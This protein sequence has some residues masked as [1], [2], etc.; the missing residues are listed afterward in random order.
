MVSLQDSLCKG[1]P[2][3][4]KIETGFDLEKSDGPGL[5]APLLGLTI[6]GLPSPLKSAAKTLRKDPLPCVIGIILLGHVRVRI[7]LPG[8]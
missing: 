5:W 1:L 6:S 2:E 3:I 4:E 7:S 8:F